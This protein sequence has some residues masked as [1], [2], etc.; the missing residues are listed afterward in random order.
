MSDVQKWKADDLNVPH[1]AT[2]DGSEVQQLYTH[3]FEKYDNDAAFHATFQGFL[4][5]IQQ[6][7][8]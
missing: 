1:P 8:L 2:E 5:A 4:D 6:R 3:F 7:S